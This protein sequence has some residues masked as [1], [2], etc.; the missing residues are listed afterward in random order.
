MSWQYWADFYDTS[1]SSLNL[2][3]RGGARRVLV[4]FTSKERDRLHELCRRARVKVK[5][6]PRLR[7]SPLKIIGFKD[8]FENGYP[9][10]HSDTI[11]LSCP[12]FFTIPESEQL[13]ILIHE[14][15]HVYQRK[16][17]IPFHKYL[18]EVKGL[19]MVGL[20]STHPDYL[21]VRRNPDVNDVIY[22]SQEGAFS[23]PLLQKDAQ[24]LGD[25]RTGHYESNGVRSSISPS[26]PSAEHPFET[27]AYNL[28][29]AILSG[30]LDPK[31]AVRY[32]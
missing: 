24:S 6:C 7:G 22:S 31:I 9:H 2:Q 12:K 32:F 21:S 27:V 10:T 28:S 14:W 5:G 19:K 3:A 23:L 25:V 8:D 26:T 13:S 29:E 4:Q 16:Y 11:F 18:F 15:I 17:P 1:L 30:D 20:I